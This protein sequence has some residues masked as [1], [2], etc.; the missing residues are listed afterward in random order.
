MTGG[1]AEG[2]STVLGYLRD[3]GYRTASSDDVS[4]GLFHSDEI[5]DA[6]LLI[7][8]NRLAHALEKVQI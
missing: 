5:Q 8:L 2:K 4:R 3:L 6:H 7:L 1:V